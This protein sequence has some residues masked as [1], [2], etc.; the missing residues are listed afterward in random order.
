MKISE[1]VLVV[2]LKYGNTKRTLLIKSI[3][4]R[5]FIEIFIIKCQFGTTILPNRTWHQNNA[6][7]ES[8]I[9]LLGVWGGLQFDFVN[10]GKQ[11]CFSA[12]IALVSALNLLNNPSISWHFSRPWDSLCP[13]GTDLN[14]NSIILNNYSFW[15]TL[16]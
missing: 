5:V 2:F 9:S 8:K 6:S 16:N 11:F 1:T 12:N 7:L 4:G 15:K 13:F 10:G 3:S 14:V